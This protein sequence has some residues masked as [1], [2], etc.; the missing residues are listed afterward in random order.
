MGTSTPCTALVCDAFGLLITLLQLGQ[1]V[2]QHL[3][4]ATDKSVV[5]VS[6]WLLFFGSLYSHLAA[7]DIAMTSGVDALTCR[8]GTWRCFIESQPL[9]QMVGSA[10]LCATMWYWFLK[11][12]HDSP[13]SMDAA[14]LALRSNVFYSLFSA[15]HFF[16]IFVSLAGVTTVWAATIVFVFGPASEVTRAFAYACGFLSAGLNAVMWLPQICVTY[17]YRHKGAVSVGWVL[18]SIVMDVVYSV[19]LAGLGVDFSVWANN[20]GDFLQT[21]VL[22]ALILYFEWRDDAQGLDAFGHADRGR[23]EGGEGVPL[24]SKEEHD[25]ECLSV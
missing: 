25:I 23:A 20:V 3:E 22:L 13:L 2:P 24:L 7:L 17:A 21:S 19:Y 4:M 6:P 1:F 16:Y 8:A 14:E 11:Y 18:A 12:H 5:G 10:L 9:L 15:R